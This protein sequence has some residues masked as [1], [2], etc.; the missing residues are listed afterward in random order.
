MAANPPRRRLRLGQHGQLHEIERLHRLVEK[1]ERG[2]IDHV[3]GIVQ[4]DQPE[5]SSAAPFVFLQGRI[6]QVQAIGLRRGP[7]ALDC[8]HTHAGI[9]R[10]SARG[11]L[12]RRR[13]VAIA[14][15]VKAQVVMRPGGD[16][17]G[18]GE[19]DDPVLVP[20]RDQ[21]CGRSVEGAVAQRTPIDDLASPTT[22]QEQP[23]PR[24][25]DGQ[26]VKR[27]EKEEDR[28]KQEQLVLDKPK[29]F[30]G[31]SW[32]HSGSPRTPLTSRP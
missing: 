1:P 2:R 26:F 22:G 6:E 10:R 18:Y 28:G 12:E 8:N 27:A 25:I 32:P 11:R 20:G 24:E 16:R 29:P 15:D 3:L 9:A 31:R 4:P 17:M 14:A 21:D 30:Q 5:R 13:V 23:E 19:F 7:V